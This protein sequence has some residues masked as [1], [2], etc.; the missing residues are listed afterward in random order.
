MLK[1]SIC[2]K[3]VYQDYPEAA[4]EWR[5]FSVANKSR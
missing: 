3:T 2:S 4:N 5:Y 1:L